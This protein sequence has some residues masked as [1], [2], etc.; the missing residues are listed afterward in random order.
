[1]RGLLAL[2]L[3]VLL[4]ATGC[5]KVMFVREG[6]SPEDFERDKWACD[7]DL[8]VLGAGTNTTLG[9]VLSSYRADLERCLTVKGWRRAPTP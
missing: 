7:R 1:M 5:A 3:V 9:Y 4:A 8:G 6:S 2:F